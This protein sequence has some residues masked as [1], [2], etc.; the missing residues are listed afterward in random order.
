MLQA[1]PAAEVILFGSYARSE[2]NAD[3]DIDV[4]VL[5]NS[6]SEKITRQEKNKIA[7]PIYDIELETGILI[8]PI[9][10]SKVAWRN[11]RVTPFYENVLREGIAL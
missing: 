8:T 11:H 5:V 1:A 10:Y 7:Y 3:S 9:V 6:D 2:E 4:L